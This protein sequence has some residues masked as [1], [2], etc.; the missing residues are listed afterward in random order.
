M[1][2]LNIIETIYESKW[3][4]TIL[5][6]SILILVVLFIAVIILAKKDAKKDKE[7]LKETIQDLK[8]VTFEQ[9]NEKEII[10][11][12]VTFEIPILTKNLENF[13]KTL[14]EEI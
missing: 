10:S 4:P 8:D 7:P 13:K 5:L 9:P 1:K 12:D 2:I 6:I 11:E 14:E 3:F